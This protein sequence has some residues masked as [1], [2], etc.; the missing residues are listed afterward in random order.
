M[1]EERESK[2]IARALH[3]DLHQSLSLIAG[4]L[5]RV[6]REMESNQIKTRMDQL[7]TIMQRTQQVA[8]QAR[9]LGMHIWPPVLGDLGLLAAISWFCKDFQK[10]QPRIQIKLQTEIQEEDV[11]D[12]LKPVAYRICERFFPGIR[13]SRK[14]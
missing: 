3:H 4:D 7:K 10:A 6:I 13:L 1:A 11:P 2:R 14:T 5:A 8:T 12:S 9:E